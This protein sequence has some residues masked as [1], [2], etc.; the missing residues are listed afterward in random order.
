MGEIVFRGCEDC[1]HVF[2]YQ[3]EINQNKC[4]FCLTP[5]HDNYCTP[6]EFA[7]EIYE[8]EGAESCY[9]FMLCQLAHDDTMA[10]LY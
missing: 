5:F 9:T 8:R 1:N 7:K 4:F 2:S 6:I 3:T 10:R